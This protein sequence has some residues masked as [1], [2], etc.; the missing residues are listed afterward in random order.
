MVPRRCLRPPAGLCRSRA[1]P[2]AD[3]PA[4][5]AAPSA[6]AAPELPAAPDLAQPPAPA[7]G[8]PAEAGRPAADGGDLQADFPG[9]LRGD[10]PDASGAAPADFRDVEAF[11]GGGAGSSGGVAGSGGGLDPVGL[12]LRAVV[13]G[14]DPERQ[15]DLSQALVKQMEMQK[16][17]HEQLEVRPWRPDKCCTSLTRCMAPDSTTKVSQI[18]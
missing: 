17:L 15:R 18:W 16:K 3:D 4:H 2:A 8:E 9:D 6:Q 12:G 10:L 13:G 7:T 1:E 5:G 14:L 11:G